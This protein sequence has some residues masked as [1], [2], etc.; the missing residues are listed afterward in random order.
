MANEPI[1][2]GME[3]CPVDIDQLKR[4]QSKF[5]GRLDYFL[6][7]TNPLLNFKSNS[8]L[9]KAER[10]VLDARYPDISL[11]SCCYNFQKRVCSTRYYIGAVA[12]R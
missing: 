4:D 5:L 8:E 10:L 3:L 12:S 11:L 7:I 1:P 9:N 6:R 2:E